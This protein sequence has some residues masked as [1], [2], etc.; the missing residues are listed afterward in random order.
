MTSHNFHRQKGKLWHVQEPSNS[1]AQE[2]DTHAPETGRKFR[3]AAG[4]WSWH[5][6]FLPRARV[7]EEKSHELE[8]AVWIWEVPDSAEGDLGGGA[9]RGDRTPLCCGK[10]VVLR[11]P[12]WPHSLSSVALS[13][14][15]PL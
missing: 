1:Q 15:Q 14:S 2:L 13:V 8:G 5:L 9:D 7:Q 6:G 4:S 10:W 12:P 3:R 11:G